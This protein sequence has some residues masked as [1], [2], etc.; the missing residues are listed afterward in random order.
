MESGAV[1]ADRRHLA[2]PTSMPGGVYVTQQSNKSGRDPNHPTL[3]TTAGREPQSNQSEFRDMLQG[4]GNHS[5]VAGPRSL[6]SKVELCASGEDIL[7]L[8][9]ATA[10]YSR[11]SGASMAAPHVSGVAALM[12]ALHPSYTNEQIRQAMR[13][14]ATDLGIAGKDVSYRFMQGIGHS[15]DV[16]ISIVG[17]T[18][19]IVK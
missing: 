16:S 3:W 11:Q 8:E 7:S 4:L 13:I 9:A 5:V 12:L 17:V 19:L 10:G 14:S 2:G 6:G 1:T 18:W 15:G